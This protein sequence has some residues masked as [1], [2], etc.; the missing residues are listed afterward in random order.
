MADLQRTVAVIFEGRDEASAEVAKVEKALQGVETAAGNST[1]KVGEADEA[2]GNVGDTSKT[3]ALEAG[4]LGEKLKKLAEDAGVP[5]EALN[6]L[7]DILK[8]VGTPVTG[9]A[10]V[11]AAALAAFALV[12]Y[13]AGEDAFTFKTKLENL[14]I[15]A[16][17]AEDQFG[18][19]SG[20]VKDLAIR[21]D[22]ALDLYAGFLVALDGTATDAKTAEDAFEGITKAIKSQGGEFK[23]TQKALEAFAKVVKDG[24]ISSEEL[25]K[26]LREIPGGLS[27]L[28]EALGVPI[29][30]L[31]QLAKEG[32]L[33]KEAIANFA[34]ELNKQEYKSLTPVKDELIG[35]WNAF[36]DVALDL[37]AEG[38]F[39]AVIGLTAEAISG[40]T[41]AVITSGALIEA[42]GETLANIAFT[43]VNKDF[44]G[45]LERQ[46]EITKKLDTSAQD[47]E[48]RFLGLRD[49]VQGAVT[50]DDVR[51]IGDLESQLHDTGGAADDAAANATK[52][53]SAQDDASKAALALAEAEKDQAKAAAQQVKVLADAEKAARDFQIKMEEI[54][55]NER[56]KFMEFKVELDI[57]QLEANAKIVE[58][59][60]ESLNTIITSTGDVISDALGALAGLDPQTDN[61]DA[62]IRQLE[63]ENE[64]R[65]EA[66]ELQKDFTQAQ[67]DY[68][69]AQIDAMNRGE[70]LI[71]VDGAGLQPHLEAFMWEILKAIQVRVNQ[72]GLAMLMG[73]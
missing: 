21:L 61:F 45:F 14:G 11:A 35:L 22:A 25:D 54:A 73:L 44:Q 62:I 60:F 23:D 66:L 27:I 56:I 32:K 16:G 37:G 43:L 33:G 13:D 70:A 28:S 40:V 59:T 18:Y 47:A 53:K 10:V 68:M 69:H 41:A 39:N 19:V 51:V 36:K 2:L 4:N 30:D 7:D 71:T 64:Y 12:A 38:G 50:D 17:D 29:E 49:S 42:F 34:A 20:A 67:I 55:S 8:R 5:K 9:S 72:D 57:A 26:E 31:A 24:K 58:A 15:A 46:A 48:R 6:G 52:L 1:K 63:L 65:Q 3:T